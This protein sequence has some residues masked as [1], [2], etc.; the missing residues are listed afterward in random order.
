[1]GPFTVRALLGEAV[2]VGLYVGLGYLC[3]I[4]EGWRRASVST[5]PAMV[6]ALVARGWPD[7]LVQGRA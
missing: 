2:W 4:V 3:C 1:M 6:A 5:L 7:A